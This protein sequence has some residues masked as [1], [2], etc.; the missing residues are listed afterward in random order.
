M[1]RS[2]YGPYALD[3]RFLTH[4]TCRVYTVNFVRRNLVQWCLAVNNIDYIK[5]SIRPFVDD[6]GLTQL[7]DSLARYKSDID[8][9]RCK[10]TLELVVDNAVD[11][12]N[13]K[14]ID[15]LQIVADKVR[16]Y[17]FFHNNKHDVYTLYIYIK[18]LW[19]FNSVYF[20]PPPI[21]D[22]AGNQ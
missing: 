15:L 3:S 2:R 17:F 9:E 7:M 4:K 12:V 19:C 6:L 11:T 20:P 1:T 21:L 14:I 8:A 13:N 10:K 16:I 5:R 22:V 18:K